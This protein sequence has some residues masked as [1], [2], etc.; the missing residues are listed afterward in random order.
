MLVLQKPQTFENRFPSETFR[1]CS[2]PCVNWQRGVPENMVC[3]VCQCEQYAYKQ[4]WWILELCLCDELIE[5]S[6]SKYRCVMALLWLAK[7]CGLIFA[8]AIVVC[9]IVLM[10]CSRTSYVFV[11]QSPPV[12]ACHYTADY[13]PGMHTTA[14]S[15]CGINTRTQRKNLTVFSISQFNSYHLNVTLVSTNY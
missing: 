2:P 14:F 15:V 1:Q 13:Q 4:W 11:F 8:F 7:T 5:V 3:R 9:L 10:A 6:P 12:C